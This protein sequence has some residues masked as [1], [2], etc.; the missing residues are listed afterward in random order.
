MENDSS[1]PGII[2]R[3]QRLLEMGEIITSEMNLD[4]LFPVIADQVNRVL[5]TERCSVFLHDEKRE[6]LWSLVS[7]DLRKGEIRI[8][9]SEGVAGC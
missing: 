3:Y 8:P 4:T 9:A 6:E 2:Q 1:T 5:N 7:T